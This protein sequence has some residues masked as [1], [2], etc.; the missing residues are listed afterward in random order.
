[1]CQTRYM[2]SQTC[3]HAWY[4]THT[5]LQSSRLQFDLTYPRI[6]LA[7]PCTEGHNLLTCPDFTEEQP[8]GPA[9]F[10]A[11]CHWAAEGECPRCDYAEYDMRRR[12]VIVIKRTGMRFGTGPG[13]KDLGVDCCQVM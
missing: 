5:A 3:H 7:L 13:K 11:R 6:E 4:T 8:Y 12:R 10:P 9:R 2:R 1:M